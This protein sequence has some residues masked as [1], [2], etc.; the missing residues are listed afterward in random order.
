MAIVDHHSNPTPEPQPA[1]TTEEQLLEERIYRSFVLREA[2]FQAC[3]HHCI[4]PITS[5]QITDL[6]I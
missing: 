1:P 5:V 2:T 3:K 6:V 4:G